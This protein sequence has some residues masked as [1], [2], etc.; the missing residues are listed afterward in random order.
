MHET[1]IQALLVEDNP[2]DIFLLQQMLA[3][4]PFWKAILT[5]TE[6][7]QSA[8]LLCRQ[9]TFDIVLLDLSLPDSHGYATFERMRQ[10]IPQTP[11]ILLTGSDD[12]ELALRAVRAGAQD[13]LVKGESNAALL[14][15]AMRYAMERKR[16]EEA[17]REHH[18]RYQ[19]LFENENI[20]VFI[21]NVDGL[22]LNVNRQA[23][24][25]LDNSVE[26]LVNT[27]LLTYIIPDEHQRFAD[28]LTALLTGQ[29]IPLHEHTLLRHNG[30]QVPIEVDS[31]VV[32]NAA[33]DILYIQSI[34]R[35]I[36]KRKQAEAA[37]YAERAQLAQRVEERTKELS[38]ANA[39]LKRSARL[40]DEFLATISHELRT[41]L[42]V[43]LTLAEALQD[44]IYGETALNQRKAL[45]RIVKSG[46][47]LLE[48]INDIIDVSKIESGK[49]ALEIGPVSVTTLCEDCLQMVQATAQPKQIQFV[50]NFQLTHDL[51]YADGRRLLQILLNL[52][53]NAVKFTPDKGRIGLEV[54]EDVEQERMMF[55]VWDTG[56]G[57]A[58]DDLPKLFR[59]FVQLD[60]KLSRH[61]QGAGLGLALV[62]RLT[63][64]HGGSVTV[65]SMPNDGSRFVIALPHQ[66]RTVQPSTALVESGLRRETSRAS[67]VDFTSTHTSILLVD[68]NE[69]DAGSVKAY[70][71]RNNYRVVL[72]TNGSDAI[73]QVQVQ[74]PS[75]ILIDTQ[76]AQMDVPETVRQLRQ[77][78]TIGRIP[79]IA[80]TA[81][82]LPSE[83]EA[84]LAA[85]ADAY[86]SKP[87]C[88]QA[89]HT[90]RV[91]GH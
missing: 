29:L 32:R 21:I 15:R 4:T 80:L 16:T 82:T 5:C 14:I 59:P 56:I 10:Q 77:L 71:E 78:P 67:V 58:G 57:I 62:Y 53:N 54:Y 17:L 63:R 87:L 9:Q 27:P 83:R 35:D 90:L 55:T 40:K 43:I 41:P 61:Y 7:L 72:V 86:M 74:A 76:V 13:Y 65:H 49:L 22:L 19:A 26:E 79:I 91:N 88:L 48:L 33:G 39:E 89:L 70:L 68:D 23:A 3:D 25:M 64:L 18:L 51:I 11:I 24:R 37:L 47:H 30:L 44:Q 8:L 6:Q 36:S 52:L 50:K 2:G 46:R 69:P 1:S 45:E 81:L 85:G 34:A 66:Q 42:S 38:I 20:G 60:S 73:T 28:H 84:C 31:S 12:Q 75:L